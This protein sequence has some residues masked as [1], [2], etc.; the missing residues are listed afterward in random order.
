M[1]FGT[2]SPGFSDG[3]CAA[4]DPQSFAVPCSG[5]SSKP[6]GRVF[7]GSG[8]PG[9]NG[10]ECSTHF[11]WGPVERNS[12]F[13]EPQRCLTLSPGF[14]S[15]VPGK[16]A[17]VPSPR[18]QVVGIQCWKRH[19]PDA[20]LKRKRSKGQTPWGKWIL[21]DILVWSLQSTQDKEFLLHSLVLCNYWCCCCSKAFHTLQ[22]QQCQ[23]QIPSTISTNVASGSLLA[24]D[25]GLGKTLQSAVL[26]QYLRDEGRDVAFAKQQFVPKCDKLTRYCEGSWLGK[27][28]IVF[29]TMLN[30]CRSTAAHGSRI[31]T[32]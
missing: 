30:L 18:L 26:L 22:D 5:G 21:L 25:M 20:F 31:L 32:S 10:I 6:P 23:S 11:G 17:Q 1:K 28:F 3:S 13:E 27:P 14:G 7:W 16:T 24:D 19:R 8:H 29:H 12:L 2:S 9:T 4:V 15:W